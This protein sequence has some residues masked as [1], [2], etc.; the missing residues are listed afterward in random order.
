[1]TT[2]TMRHRRDKFRGRHLE[3]PKALYCRQ[4]LPLRPG[5]SVAEAA[6]EKAAQ[7]AA[8]ASSASK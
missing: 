4:H 2:L 5:Y 8:E 6:Q 7:E 1:M 3:E